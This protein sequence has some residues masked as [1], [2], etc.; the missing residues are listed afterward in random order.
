MQSLKIL[1]MGIQGVV[2]G[3]NGRFCRC[4][5]LAHLSAPL[6]ELGLLGLDL[7]HRGFDALKALLSGGRIHLNVLGGLEAIKFF[8]D[9]GM[10]LITKLAGDLGKMTFPAFGLLRPVRSVV[11]CHVRQGS[12]PESCQGSRAGAG[13]LD[14]LASV[15]RCCCVL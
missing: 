2:D 14:E 12:A 7:T 4:G 11:G 5:G 10:K 9:R 6:G 3:L 15:R 8:A 1:L 13:A